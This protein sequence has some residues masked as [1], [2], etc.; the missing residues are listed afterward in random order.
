MMSNQPQLQKLQVQLSQQVKSLP[1]LYRK[2][3][4]PYDCYQC[5][6]LI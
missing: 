5:K 1:L 4:V 6:N 2:N 3:N